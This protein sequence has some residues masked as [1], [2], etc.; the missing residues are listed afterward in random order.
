MKSGR[1]LCNTYVPC[2]FTT[3][4]YLL[5]QQQLQFIG[6]SGGGGKHQDGARSKIISKSGHLIWS[7]FIW[8]KSIYI[9]HC[10]HNGKFNFL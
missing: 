9:G 5:L 7:F 1:K 2:N 6:L 4:F 3:L 10:M 8:G